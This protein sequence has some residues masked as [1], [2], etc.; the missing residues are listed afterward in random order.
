MRIEFSLFRYIFFQRQKEKIIYNKIT[1]MMHLY[2]NVHTFQ[3]IV[4]NVM[5]MNKLDARD[6]ANSLRHGR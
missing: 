6:P 4:I 5:K 3:H 2:C 1:R